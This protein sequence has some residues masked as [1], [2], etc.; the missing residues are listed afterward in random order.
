MVSV[1]F[2]I[3]S[4]SLTLGENQFCLPVSCLHY[5]LETDLSLS[6]FQVTVA[7]NFKMREGLILIL[8]VLL[9]KLT[10]S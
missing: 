7:V 2:I 4:C 1:Q 3:F 9:P 5:S 6:A 10:S 8:E